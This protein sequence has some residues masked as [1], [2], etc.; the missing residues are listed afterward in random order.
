MSD[1]EIEIQE[2]I[3]ES[4]NKRFIK[5]YWLPEH[6]FQ[7]LWYSIF[8]GCPYEINTFQDPYGIVK[9]GKRDGKYIMVSYFEGDI[10][11]ETYESKEDLLDAVVVSANW[12][13]VNFKN[14]DARPSEEILQEIWDETAFFKIK[15]LE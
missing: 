6:I 13:R 12:Y 15:P 11:E 9:F 7:R 8:E 10:R 4:G 2:E 3:L 14:L 5:E 1:A